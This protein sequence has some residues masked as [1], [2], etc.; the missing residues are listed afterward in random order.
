MALPTRAEFLS[1]L[2]AKTCDI[3]YDD[4]TGPAKTPCGHVYCLECLLSWLKQ[5]NTCPTCRSILFEN[6]TNDDENAIDGEDDTEEQPNG[7]AVENHEEAG[8]PPFGSTERLQYEMTAV[9]NEVEAELDANPEPRIATFDASAMAQ[10]VAA[11]RIDQRLRDAWMDE[12]KSWDVMYTFVDRDN[13]H[14]WTFD[15]ISYDPP[16]GPDTSGSSLGEQRGLVTNRHVMW[17]KK[18]S[19]HLS[20]I[21]ANELSNRVRVVRVLVSYKPELTEREV[22]AS[23]LD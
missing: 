21:P 12:I 23:P 10:V 19:R 22:V 18:L 7:N 11:F 3:C 5:H 8:V 15:H 16:S 9:L 13:S 20:S 14:V 2:G 17:A 1:G 6:P 4:M